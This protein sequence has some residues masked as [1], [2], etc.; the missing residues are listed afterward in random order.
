[1]ASACFE[2]RSFLEADL[3]EAE[4]PMSEFEDLQSDEGS[5][6]TV[7]S[8]LPAFAEIQSLSMRQMRFDAWR[9]GL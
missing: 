4:E 1:M 2:A 9:K 6:R 5:P 3:S 7:A 8:S